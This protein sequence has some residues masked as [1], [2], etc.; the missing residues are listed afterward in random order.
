MHLGL[1]AVI[2]IAHISQK[3]TEN[4]QSSDV[5][6]TSRLLPVASGAARGIPLLGPEGHTADGTGCKCKPEAPTIP[7]SVP[8]VTLSLS[9]WSTFS[10]E[11]PMGCG[12][13]CHVNFPPETVPT[14]SQTRRIDVKRE[15]VNLYRTAC[16]AFLFLKERILNIGIWFDE[17]KKAGRRQ[18][19]DGEVS[20]EGPQG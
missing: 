8:A 2:K 17:E 16:Q 10:Q 7:D 5:P 15:T 4:T 13:N 1:D 9:G 3:H 14:L 20:L 11:A 18:T 12:L 19:A 6:H